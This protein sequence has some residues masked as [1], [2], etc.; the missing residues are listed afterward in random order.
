MSSTTILPVLLFQL[1]TWPNDL[2]MEEDE[3]FRPGLCIGQIDR[4]MQPKNGQL[5]HYSPTQGNP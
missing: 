1:V 2:L 4:F 5:P 3:K